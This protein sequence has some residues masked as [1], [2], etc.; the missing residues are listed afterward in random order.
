MEMGQ[1]KKV[2]QGLPNTNKVKQCEFV[3]SF[4]VSLFIQFIQRE[5][6]VLRHKNIQWRSPSSD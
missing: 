5:F 1:N 3:S 6:C 2:G 4:E